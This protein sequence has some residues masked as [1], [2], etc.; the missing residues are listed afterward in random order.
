MQGLRDCVVEK[1]LIACVGSGGCLR[2][3]ASS[4]VGVLGSVMSSAA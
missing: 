1:G 3:Q 4:S 2:G